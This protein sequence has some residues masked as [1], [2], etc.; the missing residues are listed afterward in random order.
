[1]TR[2]IAV[3]GV[4]VVRNILRE[5]YFFSSPHLRA[6]LALIKRGGRCSG[7]AVRRMAPSIP[8]GKPMNGELT[9]LVRQA[10]C[11]GIRSADACPL[12]TE[13]KRLV[14]QAAEKMAASS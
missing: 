3:D 8:L 5:R 11:D 2:Q 6:H 4:P 13:V 10:S 12:A 9:D 1:M 14:N 7:C